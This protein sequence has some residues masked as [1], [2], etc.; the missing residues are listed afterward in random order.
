[1]WWIICAAKLKTTALGREPTFANCIWAAWCCTVAASAHT[2]QINPLGRVLATAL[3]LGGLAT[4]SMVTSTLSVT[5]RGRLETLQAARNYRTVFES[6]HVIV[7]GGTPSRLEPILEQLDRSRAFARADGR[8]RGKQTV[9]VIEGEGEGVEGQGGFRGDSRAEGLVAKLDLR[10][11][12]VLCRNGPLSSSETF[13][14]ALADKADK[15][16]LLADGNSR[17]EADARALV[18][19]LAIEVRRTSLPRRA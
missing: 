12:K 19:L 17:S 13:V 2:H 1:M 3:T 18:G 5:L 14:R 7:A 6:G 9:I 15:V 16:V 8:V 11:L 10:E 4:Y